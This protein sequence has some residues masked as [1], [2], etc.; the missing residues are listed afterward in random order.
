MTTLESIT[1]EEAM[2][3][4]DL[5]PTQREVVRGLVAMLRSARTVAGIRIDLFTYPEWL[6]DKFPQFVGREY[7]GWLVVHTDHLLLREAGAMPIAPDAIQQELVTQIAHGIGESVERVLV[8]APELLFILN[9]Q[10]EQPCESGP[11]RQ[12]EPELS[13]LEKER[14]RLLGD[15]PGRIGRARSWH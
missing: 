3:R 14:L 2:V 11:G 6:V 7:I 10:K 13:E 1:P 4:T 12:I 5:T 8:R 15:L 9:V